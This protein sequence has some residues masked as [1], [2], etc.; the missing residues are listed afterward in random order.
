MIVVLIMEKGLGG[1][2]GDILPFSS[3]IVWYVTGDI[4]HALC[5]MYSLQCGPL[6]AQ[7][8]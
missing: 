7:L 8:L 5:V 2:G 4:V 3:P 1:V 6:G